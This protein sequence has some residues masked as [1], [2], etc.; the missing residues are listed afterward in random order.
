[1]LHRAVAVGVGPVHYSF[2]SMVESR[3]RHAVAG[4]MAG[5]LGLD[6]RHRSTG[7]ANIRMGWM[8]HPV[9][10]YVLRAHH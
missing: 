3:H 1:M 5:V 2:H 4:M 7:L 6:K 9:A 8:T 10:C